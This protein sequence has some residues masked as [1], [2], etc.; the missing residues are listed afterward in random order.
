MTDP[1][2]NSPSA[3]E[4]HPGGP[5][6]SRRNG[7]PQPPVPPGNITLRT[8]LEIPPTR[9]QFIRGPKLP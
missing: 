8:G 1:H 6:P 7:V 3:P 9:E 5:S 2:G 4:A